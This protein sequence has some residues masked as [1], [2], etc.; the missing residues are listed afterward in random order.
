MADNFRT[1]AIFVIAV[2]A[3]V[4]GAV[5]LV[6]MT[7]VI[8]L[9]LFAGVIG[10]LL[11]STLTDWTQQKLKIRRG[12]ALAVVVALLV[13]GV[14]MGVWMRGPALAQQ[15]SD[16]QIDLPTAVHKIVM[17]LQAQGLGRW[18]LSRYGDPRQ[19]SE[20]LAFALQRIGGVV[21]TTVSTVVGLF[22]IAAVSLYVAAEPLT[23]LRGIYQITPAAYRHM[24]E[25]C[26]AGATQML[27]SWLIAKGIS[28]ITVGALVSLGLWAL[29]I[30]LAGTLGMI[31]GSLTFIPN[32]GPVISV[33]PA[34]LLAFAISP[35]KGIL[36]LLLFCLVHL[37][38]GSVVTPLLER[39]IVTLPPALTL[40]VQLLLAVTAGAI[41]VA[42]AAPLTAAALGILHVLFPSEPGAPVAAS[43]NHQPTVP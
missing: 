21:I 5:T 31:A 40:A 30:P 26:M 9:L 33:L 27:R 2:C 16:L 6:W 25:L 19:F 7:R 13:I 29:Q 34:S 32:L 8:L 39:Q 43:L 41:G 42:L 18:L 22:V 23:Y 37:L 11:L 28:M 4:A 12:L 38:E 17:R 36:T 14:V 24:L 20:G 1:R 3:A 15:F 35:T 10:A